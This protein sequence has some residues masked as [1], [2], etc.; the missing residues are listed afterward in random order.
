VVNHTFQGINGKL[1]LSILMTHLGSDLIEAPETVAKEGFGIAA[2]L[3]FASSTLMAK[4]RH[5]SSVHAH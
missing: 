2:S 3:D 4:W 1:A 5:K